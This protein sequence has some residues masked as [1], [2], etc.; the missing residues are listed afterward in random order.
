MHMVFGAVVEV[1][2]LC[3]IIRYAWKWPRTQASN[4]TDN[5]NELSSEK[6][7]KKTNKTFFR[8]TKDAFSY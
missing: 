3:L 2:L 7:N 6:N 4:R 1:V 5:F 8:K